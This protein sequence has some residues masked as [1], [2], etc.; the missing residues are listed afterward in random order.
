VIPA[1]CTERA[2]GGADIR[3]VDVP[4]ND[5]RAV[6][7][8]VHPLGGGGRPLAQ[9]VQRGVVVQLQRLRVGETRGA[10]D[11]GVDVEREAAHVA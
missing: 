1:K 5:V 2:L 11:D 8:R 10:G 3:V 9:V 6:I 7:L 4:V